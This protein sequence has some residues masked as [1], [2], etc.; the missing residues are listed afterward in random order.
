MAFYVFLAFGGGK[1]SSWEWF[2]NIG[3][4]NIVIFDKKFV[5]L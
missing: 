2:A 4:A 3:F 1:M 5:T